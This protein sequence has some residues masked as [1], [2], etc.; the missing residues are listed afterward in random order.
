M[1]YLVASTQL[2]N[3]MMRASHIP[4]I[5]SQNGLGMRD[6]EYGLCDV[7]DTIN[8]HKVRIVGHM[9]ERCTLDG[10]LPVFSMRSYVDGTRVSRKRLF[11]I[12]EEP[13]SPNAEVSRERSESA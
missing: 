2:K 12:C 9:V 7:T 13:M 4:L 8:G 10:W 6:Y 3:L 5:P 1:R 11:E